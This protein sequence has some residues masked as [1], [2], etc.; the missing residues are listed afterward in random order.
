MEADKDRNALA[1]SRTSAA[2]LY[3]YFWFIIH[4]VYDIRKNK[5][6]KRL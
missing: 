6:N 1:S 5:P 4:M 3:C 2:V